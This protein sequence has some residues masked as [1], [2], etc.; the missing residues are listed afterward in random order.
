MPISL[1]INRLLLSTVFFLLLFACGKQETSPTLIKGTVSDRKTGLPIEGAIFQIGFVTELGNNEDTKYVSF[2]T[3]A[4]GEF[5]YTEYEDYDYLNGGSNI[6]KP[7]YVSNK[8]FSIAKG[9]DNVLNPTL[10]PIDAVL[11]I[12]VL[13][14]SGTANPFYFHLINPEET[15]EGGGL[16]AYHFLNEKPLF[17]SHNQEYFQFFKLP[18]STNYIYWD[19]KYFD[20]SINASFKDTVPVY[21]FDTVEY[22]IVY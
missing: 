21:S 16:T 12:I 3:D 13:N 1:Y 4:S 14:Q 15:L 6:S 19:T 18:K 22:K 10:L 11:K 9:E 5:N 20:S 7:G 8:N 2:S 17:L